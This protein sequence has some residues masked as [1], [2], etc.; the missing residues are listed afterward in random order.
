MLKCSDALEMLILLG[1]F[2]II[3]IIRGSSSLSRVKGSASYPLGKA[4]DGEPPIM[5]G[6]TSVFAISVTSLVVSFVDPGSDK[7]RDKAHDKEDWNKDKPII[8]S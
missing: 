1:V 3:R 8:G 4:R 2:R 7:A 5:H 6:G